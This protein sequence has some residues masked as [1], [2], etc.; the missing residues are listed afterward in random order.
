[1]II[2]KINFG[3]LFLIWLGLTVVA[4]SL[5]TDAY[6]QSMGG[7]GNNSNT[8][9]EHAA[10]TIDNLVISEHIPLAGQ[11]ANGD[12]ILLMDFT[13]FATSVEGHSHIALKVPC[14]DDGSPKIS[15]VTGGAPK[16]NTLDIGKPIINGT[17]DGKD[18]ELSVEGK[19][20]LYHSDLPNGIT[21]IA[22]INTSNEALNFSDNSGYSVTVSIHGTAIQHSARPIP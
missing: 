20:C 10:H 22:L 8:S 11:L 1:L 18:L 5:P 12:Y 15:I 19:S 6:S 4:S 3:I 2:N 14:K 16:L 17:L 21:D 13:P 7:M 9:Q